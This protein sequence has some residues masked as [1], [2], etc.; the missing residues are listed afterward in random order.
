MET[1]QYHIFVESSAVESR[2]NGIAPMGYGFIIL[3]D[4]IEPTPHF[5]YGAEKDTQ[6]MLAHGLYAAANE[7]FR[8]WEEPII[9]VIKQGV[10]TQKYLTEFVPNWRRKITEG[11]QGFSRHNLVVW[12]KLYELS[13]LGKQKMIKPDSIEER[14]RVRQMKRLARDYAKEAQNHR[15]INESRY[16]T[17][18]VFVTDEGVSISGS[19]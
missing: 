11:A 4:G 6:A 5:G 3:G 16:M 14:L 18:G 13:L 1:K 8:E 2:R 7:I 19:A 9:T 12:E 17:C 15:Q 10:G